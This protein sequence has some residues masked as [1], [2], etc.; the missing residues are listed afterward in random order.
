[1]TQLVLRA[2]T[3]LAITR[4]ADTLIAGID[5][6]AHES[7]A[8]SVGAKLVTGVK[9][10]LAVYPVGSPRP[11]GSYGYTSGLDFDVGEHLFHLK[12]DGL[13]VPGIHYVVEIHVDVFE[14]DVPPQHMWSP[15]SPRYKV[16]W[17]RMLSQTVN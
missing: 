13:P 6:E 7:A 10:T 15:E 11:P 3:R 14:T 1:M 9:Y 5:P 12:P 16:V 4:T 2:P 17:S 8:I